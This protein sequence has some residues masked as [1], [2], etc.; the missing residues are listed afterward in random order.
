VEEIV[1]MYITDA[2][3]MLKVRFSFSVKCVQACLFFTP[4]QRPLPTPRTPP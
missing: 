3:D 1:D 2:K 4:S